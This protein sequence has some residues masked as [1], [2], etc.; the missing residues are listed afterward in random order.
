MTGV[1][2]AKVGGSWVNI[3]GSGMSAETARWNSAWGIVANGTVVSG[4]PLKVTTTETLLTST[5]NMTMVS[6]RRY[7]IAVSARATT[8]NPSAGVF[9][10]IWLRSSGTHQFSAAPITFAP[11][12]VGLYATLFYEWI[13]DGD[14]SAKAW[15]VALTGNAPVDVYSDQQSYFYVED[16]GP[17]IYNAAPAPIGTPTAWTPLTMLNN[18][19]AYGSPYPTPSYRRVGD[20]VQIRAHI[21]NATAMTTV[22]SYSIFAS[23]PVG[24]RAVCDTYVAGISTGADGYG[25]PNMINADTAGNLIVMRVTG[26]PT[27]MH[28]FTSVEGQFSTTL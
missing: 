22:P 1:L 16:V 2:K 6:G 23:L 9:M 8:S 24:S 17:V 10:Q 21:K 11:N 28:V 20:M 14:G 27:Q 18:W 19:T 7:R 12:N 13:I 25:A 3:I 4:N 5:I 26:G 15:S